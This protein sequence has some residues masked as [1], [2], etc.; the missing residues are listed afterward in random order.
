MNQLKVELKAAES[1]LAELQGGD[2]KALME[3]EKQARIDSFVARKLAS[4]KTVRELEQQLSAE[5]DA[6]GTRLKLLNIGLIPLCL[7]L[8]LLLRLALRW[9]RDGVLAMQLERS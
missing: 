3:V 5:T 1:A 6:L 7:T 9:A 8:I 4:R 2:T